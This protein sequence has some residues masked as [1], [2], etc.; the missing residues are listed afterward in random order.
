MKRTIISMA[1]LATLGFAHSEESA[2]SLADIKLTLSTPSIS[3]D[4]SANRGFV[5]PWGS[6]YSS[7][8]Q[9]GSRKQLPVLPRSHLWFDLPGPGYWKLYHDAE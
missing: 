4:G 6:R 3:I 5:N 9:I 8:G 1:C 7:D 2:N